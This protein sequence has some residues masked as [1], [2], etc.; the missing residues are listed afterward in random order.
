MCLEIIYLIYVQKKNLAL[1]NLQLLVS[2][3]TKS[4]YCSLKYVL[5]LPY[6]WF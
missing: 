5:F 3:K 2:H 4:G 1:N 6:L